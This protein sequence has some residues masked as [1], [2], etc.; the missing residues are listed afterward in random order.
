MNKRLFLGAIAC[1]VLFSTV[2][3]FAGSS[4]WIG[5]WKLNASKSRI[6]GPTFTLVKTPAGEYQSD[7]GTQS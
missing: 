5:T 3:C 2:P 7:N 4:A 6:P 1:I